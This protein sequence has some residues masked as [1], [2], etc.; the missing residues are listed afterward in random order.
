M[1]SALF[2]GKLYANKPKNKVRPYINCHLGA[3]FINYESGQNLILP[4]FSA[5][6]F[7]EID[8]HFNFGVSAEGLMPIA[9]LKVGYR[10]Y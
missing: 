3:E 2:G 5:G 9:Y 7:L 4:A 10:F 8:E 6:V 1:F